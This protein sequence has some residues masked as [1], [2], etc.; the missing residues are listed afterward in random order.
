MDQTPTWGS[1]FHWMF[2]FLGQLAFQW[3]PAT[4]TTLKDS[5][6][7]GGAPFASPP[8]GPAPATAQQVTDYLQA[9]SI[10]GAYDALTRDWSI[11]VVLSLFISLLLA[12]L[13]IYC[14]VRIFQIRH[15]ERLK[16]DAA[17]E[18]VTARDVS[19]SQLRWNRIMEEI[20]SDSE[21]DLR[22]AI[23]EAD[24]MLGELLDMLGYKGETMADKMRQV[25]RANFNTIDLAWEAHRARNAIA[26]QGSTAPISSRDARHVI[27]LYQR[28]F[29]EFKFIE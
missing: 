14:V 22:L 23:L 5:G 26:H 3:V 17:A 2:N 9:A 29:R 27:N 12:A 13:I 16:F 21:H 8:L 24:I 18:T 28:I 6:T 25:D 11:F 15:H 1:G 4:I 19:R 10:P 20:S 7:S